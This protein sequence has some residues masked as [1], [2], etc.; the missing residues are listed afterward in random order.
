MNIHEKLKLLEKINSYNFGVEYNNGDVI[1]F[2]NEENNQEV[3]KEYI[4]VVDHWELKD[5]NTQN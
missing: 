5:D 2:P 4:F 3:G 1:V